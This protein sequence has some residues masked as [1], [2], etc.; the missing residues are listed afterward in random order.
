MT[1]TSVPPDE[2]IAATMARRDHIA[3]L[4]AARAFFNSH[5]RARIPDSPLIQVHLKGAT[6]DERLADLRAI[7]NSWGVALQT[8]ADGTR[9]A[10]LVLG[11]LTYEA[12][13]PPVPPARH[14]DWVAAQQALRGVAA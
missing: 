12:H 7:A 4:G 3:D 2:A 1:L 5:P 10:Q 6:R 9:S 14:E 8:L 11:S 13:L